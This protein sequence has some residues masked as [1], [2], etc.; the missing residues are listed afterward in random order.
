MLS[1]EDLMHLSTLFDE[2]IENALKRNNIF[3]QSEIQKELEKL[4]QEISHNDFML[5]GQ[6]RHEDAMSNIKLEH[7]IFTLRM[8]L[9]HALAMLRIELLYGSTRISTTPPPSLQTL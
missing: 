4:R 1:N 9:E 6:L 8:D 7:S 3:V 5:Y 2:K